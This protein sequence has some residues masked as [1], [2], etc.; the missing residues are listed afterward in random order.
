MLGSESANPQIFKEDYLI[1]Y[2]LEQLSRWLLEFLICDKKRSYDQIVKAAR[3]VRDELWRFWSPVDPELL[4]D[5]TFDHTDLFTGSE[6]EEIG[7][8]SFRTWIIYSEPNLE[9]VP[10]DWL[11]QDIWAFGEPWTFSE[12]YA[13]MALWSAD[14]AAVYVN[15]GKPY[16]ASIWL[17]RTYEQYYWAINNELG[18][19]EAFKKQQA[20]QGGKAKRDK[21]IPLKEFV[22]EL[23]KSKSY[24][25]RRNA[26]QS[27]KPAVLEKAKALGI[28]LS[29]MQ[30][31][32]TITGW[33]KEMGLPENIIR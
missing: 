17:L 14:E 26:A 30:A 16:K 9:D 18:S 3:I 6:C 7:P 31:E 2:E 15:L 24:P 1:R 5:P 28:A 21:Y 19:I 12:I 23:V 27:I 25:S 32:I 4:L 29:D 10:D 33:L 22:K 20:S 13:V 11:Q 8:K